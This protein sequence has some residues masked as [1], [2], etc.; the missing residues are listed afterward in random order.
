MTARGGGRPPPL[1]T[2]PCDRVPRLA[3][4]TSRFTCA[5]R[6]AARKR[7]ADCV[8]VCVFVSGRASE[9]LSGSHFSHQKIHLRLDVKF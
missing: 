6:V 7:T 2:S 1:R 3:A 8:S 5:R 4:V 9:E